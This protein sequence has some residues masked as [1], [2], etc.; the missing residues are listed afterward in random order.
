MRLLVPWALIGL[1]AS[2]AV[3]IGPIY[4][5]AFWAQAVFYLVA[6]AGTIRVVATRSSVAAASASVLILNIAAWVAFWIWISGRADRTW[7]KFAL[8]TVPQTHEL[9]D[10]AAAGVDY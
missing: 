7:G 1:A 6:F 4:R 10:S 9:R 5:A 8:E 2:A 3:L